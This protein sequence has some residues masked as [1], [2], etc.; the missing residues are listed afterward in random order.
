MGA[1][2]AYIYKAHIAG[3]W[4]T[5]FADASAR[6]RPNANL[7]YRYGQRCRDAKMQ[8]QGA[9]LASLEQRPQVEPDA[10]GRTLDELFHCQELRKAA[11]GA[12]PVL[13]RDVLLPGTQVFAARMRGGSSDGFYVAAQGGHNN[14]SHNHNDVG[15]FIVYFGGE[16]VLVDVGVEDLH[17]QDV[18]RRALLHLDHAIG[19]AQLPHHQRRRTGRRAAV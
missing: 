5:N 11:A 4:Y 2:G 17:G 13:E 1:I 9:W 15:N 10:L 14:E 16:P 8:Q 6:V 19:L 7:V 12:K 18:F 3:E